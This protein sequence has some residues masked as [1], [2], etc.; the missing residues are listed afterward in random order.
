MAR[1]IVKV[2]VPNGA[3]GVSDIS[4]TSPPMAIKQVYRPSAQHAGLNQ[5]VIVESDGEQKWPIV[6]IGY[7]S[8]HRELL[9][10]L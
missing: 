6:C 10:E 9:L 7:A 5:L 4:H 2:I 3:G 1:T 8:S